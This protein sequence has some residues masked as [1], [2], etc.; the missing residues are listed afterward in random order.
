MKRILLSLMLGGLALA[1]SAQVFPC[2]DTRLP[3]EER[4]R[5]LV[6]RLTL[7]EKAALSMNTSP[8]VERLGIAP[9][10]WWNEALHGVARNGGATVFPQAIGMAASFDTEL[11]LQ[12]FTAISDEGRVKNR[13]ARER[14]E[15]HIYQ[16]LTFWTP[17]INIF[18]DPRWGRG[19]ETYGEDPYL[20]GQMG[21][22]AVRGLQGDLDAPVLKAHACA[23]H[24]AVHSGPESSRH[25]FN[26]DISE[27]DL[28]ET[29]LPAFKELVTKG[30]VQEV[31]TAYNRFRGKPCTASNYLVNEILRGEW[32]Y[33]GLVV[34]DCWAISDFYE[35]GRHNY[36]YSAAEAAAAAVRNG[37]EIECGESYTHIPEAVHR[38]LL[39]ESLLDRNLTRAFTQRY[40]LGEMDGWSP[41]DQLDSSIIEGPQHRALSRQMARESLVLL[42]NRDRTLPLKA[43][44][45]LALIGPNA[46]DPEM[47]WGNYNGV[48]NSTVTLRTAL[49][50][51]LPQL[52]SFRACGLV[53]AEDSLQSILR[54]LDGIETVV[55]AGGI[56]PRLEGEEM[57]VDVPGFAGGDRTDIGLPA[58]QRQLLQALHD[59]GKKVIL[60]NFSGGAMGLEPETES[61]DAIL[62]AW[63]PGQDGGTAIADILLGEALPSGKLPVTFYASA[64]ELP[65]FE[66]YTMEGHTYRYYRGEPVF[67]FGHGLS[68]VE[69]KY[70][71]AKV[72]NGELVVP[73]KNTGRR[74]AT[75]VVQLYVRRED[76]EEGPNRTL[77]GFKRVTIPAG[78]T[79]QVRFALDD[80]VFTWWDPETET[81]RPL[82][83]DYILYYGGSSDRVRSLDYEF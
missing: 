28:R 32:G 49:K 6:A 54:R 40:R 82:P 63:Y 20:T 78:A 41:W 42:Q 79:V 30:G 70:G 77:R 27:R 10:N 5:D 62:Q 58:V 29:Y 61:C 1:A 24:L 75:E 56:S 69:F 53:E 11:M 65:D 3:A 35:K 60:V 31:M 73:V 47:Q 43:T 72:R 46:D 48:P 34:S 36:T 55:F 80:E 15:V 37:V 68:Y 26:A 16:G 57:A 9:Y 22:M 59:A 23:K 21:T 71:R 44:A 67:A 7:E 83:G 2:Q 14:G 51:R 4:A 17:N 39:D 52:V 81:M 18:R 76:D 66:D 64:Q 19:M 33:Q 38:G 50:A 8:G 74:P 13:L 12:V 45:P 25:R